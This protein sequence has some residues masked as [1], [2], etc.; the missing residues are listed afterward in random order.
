MKHFLSFT[1]KAL[2][3]FLCFL[4]AQSTFSQDLEQVLKN[5]D[6]ASLM[7][8]INL[9]RELGKQEEKKKGIKILQQALRQSTRLKGGYL[10]ETVQSE[11]A[12]A[13][14]ELGDLSMP[15]TILAGITDIGIRV[16]TL[17]A[18]APKTWPQQK[19][20]GMGMLEE[21]M[22][23]TRG[24]AKPQD[25][26]FFCLEISGSYLEMGQRKAA[27]L[28]L[29]DVEKITVGLQ[30]KANPE[31]KTR[32]WTSLG[33]QY[34][35]LDRKEKSAI[36]FDRAVKE[37]N[38]MLNP[39]DKAQQLA[40]IGGEMAR[41]QLL[42]QAMEVLGQALE[43]SESITAKTNQENVRSDIARSIGEAGQ[44]DNAKLLTASI[45]DHKYRSDAQLQLL[46]RMIQQQQLGNLSYLEETE[47]S[48]KQ[49][50]DQLVQFL[51]LIRLAALYHEAQHNEKAQLILQ[52]VKERHE[53]F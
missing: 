32:L 23:L 16:R 10:T 17:C 38:L 6:A 28:L 12:V 47:A 5:T 14:A 40:Y 27:A 50:E 41:A 15:R 21:A 35:V 29:E 31:T 22:M 49:I 13:F 3:A 48:V 1:S 51:Q 11:L 19:E 24:K 43:V 37:A 53:N 36:C 26:L 42:E 4:I 34:F 46:N 18:V 44:F 39:Y 20:L 52:N 33:A 30:E 45:G 9:G 25:K 8:Q 2:A 7:V